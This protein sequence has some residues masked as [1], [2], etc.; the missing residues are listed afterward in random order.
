M[1]N[2]QWLEECKELQ[3]QHLASYVR[4]PSQE[5][6]AQEWLL[7]QIPDPLKISFAADYT[8]AK[9]PSAFSL[10]LYAPLAKG[11]E[12][13]RPLSNWLQL[14]LHA[15]VYLHWL[16]LETHTTVVKE[17][18]R[19]LQALLPPHWSS[20]ADPNE[21]R[22]ICAPLYH[23]RFWVS[24]RL[25]TEMS[26]Y[27]FLAVWCLHWCK[28]SNKET[29]WMSTV[30]FGVCYRFRVSSVILAVS[31]TFHII[32]CTITWLTSSLSYT[33]ATAKINTVTSK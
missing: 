15:V 22:N 17:V 9:I 28:E 29:H 18:A 1:H 24:D 14:P 11:A 6:T 20:V 8:D 13:V 26:L 3:Y 33:E 27:L 19:T 2:D 21:L 4:T 30:I 5:S 25:T 10:F 31:S 16:I 23:C 12:H 32:K 7:R